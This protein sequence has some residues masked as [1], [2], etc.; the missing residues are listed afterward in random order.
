[1]AT[2][3]KLSAIDTPSTGDLLAVFD[4][5]NGDHRKAALSLLVTFLDAQLT[6]PNA[7][8]ERQSA[9]VTAT[10]YSVA[11]TDSGDWVW[12]FIT[13]G[14]DYAAAT[15]VYPAT[16][17]DQ[18]ELYFRSNYDVTTLTTDANGKTVV[19]AEVEIV[20]DT[21]YRFKYDSTNET[22]YRVGV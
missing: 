7:D 1:M 10:A 6:F 15:I 4:T 21:L 20:A 3:N 17:V 22:W 14:G 18:Q 13:Q 19:G 5:S 12:L 16:P 9:V 8:F 11:V 2:I